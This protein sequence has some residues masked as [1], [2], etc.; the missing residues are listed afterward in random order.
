MAV[1]DTL[2]CALWAEIAGEKSGEVIASGVFIPNL[3]K[4]E[5][6]GLVVQ[7]DSGGVK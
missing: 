6:F 4:P 2:N 3:P 1:G 7:F 5:G